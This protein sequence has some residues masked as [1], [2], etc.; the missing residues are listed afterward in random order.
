MNPMAFVERRFFQEQI[1]QSELWCEF[2]FAE[3]TEI[4]SYI[5]WC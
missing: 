3:L 1:Y 4:C 5:C 2:K